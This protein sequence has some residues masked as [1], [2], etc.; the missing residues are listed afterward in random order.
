MKKIVFIFWFVGLMSNI[1]FAQELPQLNTYM[2]N[3]FIYNPASG[4]MYETD[5]NCNIA[6]R[7]QWAGVSG[8]PLTSF[9]WADHRFRKNSMSAGLYL[10]YD[11]IGARQF[12]EAAANYTYILRLDNKWKLSFGLRAGFTSATFNLASSDKV[13]DQNDPLATGYVMNYPKFGGGAQLYSRNFYVGIGVPDIASINSSPFANDKDKNFF[14]KNRNYSLLTGYRWRLTDGLSLLPSSKVFYYPNNPVRVDLTA[15]LEITDY[16]WAGGSYISTGSA[17]VMAGS[18]ISSR[19]R[20]SYAYEF[21]I[22]SQVSNVAMLNVHE[23]LLMIQLDDL[24]ARKNK[25]VVE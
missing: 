14:Q 20:F 6:S 11:R 25:K 10:A 18:Y 3:Q 9:A 15:L 7:F 13:F 8:A 5:F 1:G 24:F 21:P 2:F 19:L 16:F 17:S 12:T 22:Q 23:I 4:G